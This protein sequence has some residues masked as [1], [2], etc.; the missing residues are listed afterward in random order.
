[1]ILDLK[2]NQRNE[3]NRFKKDGLPKSLLE[4][5]IL[6]ACHVSTNCRLPIIFV[7]TCFGCQSTWI[8]EE[9]CIQSLRIAH[10]LVG[11][12]LTTRG[13]W[14]VKTVRP[15]VRAAVFA[16]QSSSVSH[17]RTSATLTVLPPSGSKEAAAIEFWFFSFLLR[18]NFLS[19]KLGKIRALLSRS[20]T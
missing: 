9:E 6:C 2:W 16:F 10:M 1:M 3:R 19:G 17:Y 11:M 5:N 12:T 20:W 13:F 8:S 15:S 14:F 18:D 4:N 7:I